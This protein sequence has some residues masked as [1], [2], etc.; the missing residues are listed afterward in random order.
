MLN[1]PVRGHDKAGPAGV[2]PYFSFLSRMRDNHGLR[3]HGA[4]LV[5]GAFD[6]RATPGM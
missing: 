2:W 3:G 5:Y 1:G 4:N 6:L